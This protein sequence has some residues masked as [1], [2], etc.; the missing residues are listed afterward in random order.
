MRHIEVNQLW[1]QDKIYAG[2]IGILKVK[3]E[4]NMADALTKA[5]ASKN[6]VDHIC[7]VG[8]EVRQGRHPLA[9]KVECSEMEDLEE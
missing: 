5:L 9:P 4:D 8:A 3:S 2:E 7:G 1:L 6:I